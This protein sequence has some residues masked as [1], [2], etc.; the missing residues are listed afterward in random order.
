MIIS[1][2][3]ACKHFIEVTSDKMIICKA[4]PKGVPNEVR[5]MKFTHDKVLEGQKGTFVYEE[6]D[7]CSLSQCGF[8]P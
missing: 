5:S 8:V 7:I 6:R 3:L 1:R 4:Y 2:C